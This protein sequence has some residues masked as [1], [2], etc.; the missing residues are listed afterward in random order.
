MALKRFMAIKKTQKGVF[1]VEAAFLVPILILLTAFFL[2][3]TISLYSEVD[4]AAQDTAALREMDS[5]EY[6][7]K[8]VQLEAFGEILSGGE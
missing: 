3:T 5:V 2:Q 6:F 7:W 1:T 4:Q 8:G